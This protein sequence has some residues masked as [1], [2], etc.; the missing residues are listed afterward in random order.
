MSFEEKKHI[1]I[2]DD[3]E[4]IRNLLVRY[5]ERH[6][7]VVM[8]AEDAVHAKEYLKEFIYDIL[9]VDV[10]MPGQ[11]GF[12]FARDVRLTS[13][14]PM[15]FLTAKTELSDKA[16]GFDSGADD[17][18]L[19]PFEPEELLMR[20][21][22]ILKRRGLNLQAKATVSIGPWVY[23][24]R[25]GELSNDTTIVRLTDVEQKLLKALLSKSGQI[26]S[27]EVLAD[28]LGVAG[29]D[30]TIDVQV[31]RLRKKIEKDPKSPRLLQTVRGKGYILYLE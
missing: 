22:A 15:L 8:A 12:E 13:D 2:I 5:L 28:H 27:R 7:C 6:D 3:D 19:K 30:R 16:E 24:R 17:Y 18:L 29:N 1:L 4:R 26:F 31:T 21:D 23:D 9:I 25:Q 14:V 20:I 11:S 10:M